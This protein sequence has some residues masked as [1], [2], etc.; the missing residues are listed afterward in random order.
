M[1]KFGYL[2]SV[3]SIT[4][5]FQDNVAHPK[6]EMKVEG[7]YSRMLRISKGR[8]VDNEGNNDKW[9]HVEHNISKFLRRFRLT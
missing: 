7:A 3:G 4:E 1:V 8:N 9:D 6:E 2:G 5:Q